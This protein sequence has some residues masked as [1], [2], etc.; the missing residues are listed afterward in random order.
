[1]AYKLGLITSA[2]Y[3][4]IPTSSQL[5]FQLCSSLAQNLIVQIFK[6]DWVCFIE[7]TAQTYGRNSTLHKQIKVRHETT[8][9]AT[10]P[11]FLYI[12]I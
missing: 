1:M 7:T 12:K 3:G 11:Y 8:L 2:V 9:Y 10:K 6:I 4:I 5:I